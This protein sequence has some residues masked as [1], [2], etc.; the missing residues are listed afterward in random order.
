MLFIQCALNFDWLERWYKGDDTSAFLQGRKRDTATRG[1]LYLEVPVR[2]LTELDGVPAGAILEVVK[3][4]YG[5]PGAPRAWWTEVTTFL[6]DVGAPTF[7]DG[8][9]LLGVVPRCW[10]RRYLVSSSRRKDG[11]DDTTDAKFGSQ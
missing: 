7:L 3:S 6:K 8:R 2:S 10:R 5:L 4:V 9:C 1:K 11:D